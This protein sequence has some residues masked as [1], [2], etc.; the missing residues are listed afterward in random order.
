MA[1]AL[2][3]IFSFEYGRSRVNFDVVT[4]KRFAA[5][6]NGFSHQ[7]VELADLLP[8]DYV[9]REREPD[10]PAALSAALTKIE[11]LQSMSSF[12]TMLKA[13]LAFAI[14]RR[15]WLMSLT[16]AKD[17]ADSVLTLGRAAL[18]ASGTMLEAR[19]PWWNVLTTPFQFLCTVLAMDTPKSLSMFRRT[20]MVS[21]FGGG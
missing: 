10:P 4:T 16:D 12:I 15:L 13:D 1:R 19:I 5:D 3:V 18:A 11:E 8:N 7:L 17:R 6:N 14:Y 20:S 21:F 9:D 2:K